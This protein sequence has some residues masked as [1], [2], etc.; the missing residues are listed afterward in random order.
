MAITDE[1]I[2]A[3]VGG[4]HGDAFAVLGPHAK[5]PT[6]KNDWEIR[7][8]LPQA[9]KVEVMMAKDTVPMERVHPAG[10]FIASLTSAPDRYRF[11]ITDYGEAVTE[12]EDVYRFPPILTEFDL[13]L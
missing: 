2:Q 6:S 3:I 7:A 5:S 8:F 10:L 13:H 12:A 1:E 4:Y 11:K 9:Q